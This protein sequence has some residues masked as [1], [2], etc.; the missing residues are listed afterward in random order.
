MTSGFTQ[1]AKILAMEISQQE[2]CI[3]YKCYFE[4]WWLF[5]LFFWHSSEV[6]IVG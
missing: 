5:V 3:F 4:P 6:D 2:Q 1:N